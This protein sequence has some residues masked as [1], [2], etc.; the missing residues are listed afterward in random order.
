MPHQQVRHPRVTQPSATVPRRTPF[1]L[2][3]L[4]TPPAFTLSQDQ[5]LHHENLSLSVETFPVTE[6]PSKRN[7]VLKLNNQQLHAPCARS[8][9][10]APTEVSCVH[11]SR[12]FSFF[13]LWHAIHR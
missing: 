12:F 7:Q 4:G 11:T 1:D 3:V 6:N 5:T 10:H 2:H 8:R 9:Q 13:F